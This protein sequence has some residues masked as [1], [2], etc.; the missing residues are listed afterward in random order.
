MLGITVIC[1]GKLNADYFSRGCAEFQ[2]RIGAFANFRVTELSEESI[3]EK[4]I[5][6]A[7]VEKA[8]N[9]EGEKIIA[10]IPKG[11]L[12]VAMCIEGKQLAS[13]ELAKLFSESAL[14]GKSEIAFI[15]GSSHGLCERVKKSADI[16]LSM[17]KMT[18]PHQLAR[19]MLYEQIYRALSINA[20]IKYHK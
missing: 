10:A 3:N 6:P 19:L 4:N 12:T 9:K 13:D 18:F 1:I 15:I 11:A 16:K 17:S 2:K 5:S 7:A 8:L 20:S 14:C